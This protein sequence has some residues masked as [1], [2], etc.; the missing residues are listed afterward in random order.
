MKTSIMNKSVIPF[1]FVAV[2]ACTST[3][4]KDTNLVVIE[5]LDA[6]L[7]Q[8]L[9]I[10]SSIEIIGEGYE[11]SEGPVWIA[12]E[13]MLLFSD[14]PQNI[15]YKWTSAKGVE[16]YLTPAGFTGEGNR[17]GSNGLL[18]NPVGNLVICQHG[19]RRMAV[20]TA[21]LDDP[22]PTFEALADHYDGK[23][24]NSPNDAAYDAQGNLYF[25]DPPY[26]LPGQDEDPDKEI[27]FNGVYKVS[28][29]GKVTLLIDSLTRPNGIA[30]SPDQKYLYVAN[31]DSNKA[32]W[33]QYELNDSSI[34]SG[35]VLYDAT[36]LTETEKGLPDGLKVDA[37]GNIFATGPGGVFIFNSEG[38]LI[39]KIKIAE[40]TANCALANNDKTLFTTSD[41]YVIKIDFK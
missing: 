40:A 10:E 30:F 38:K 39:G 1:I 3:E 25:T 7:D 36:A 24:F 22:K 33:Y 19:D 4:K 41:M 28:T 31:S 26:G 18:L 8:I 17:E 20:M 27:P 11:W 12:E 37:K 9:S 32:R 15:I 14:V 13:N 21:T 5:R 34:V 6:A 35:K 23:K 2:A 16:K 29:E